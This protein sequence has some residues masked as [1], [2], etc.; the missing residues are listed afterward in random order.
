[1]N[2]PPCESKVSHASKIQ[3]VWDFLCWKIRGVL[4][5]CQSKGTTVSD[6]LL[7]STS[8]TGSSIQGT[9][10]GS[11]ERDIERHIATICSIRFTAHAKIPSVPLK[12]ARNKVVLLQTLKTC[13]KKCKLYDFRFNYDQTYNIDAVCTSTLEPK[14]PFPKLQS[15]L[16]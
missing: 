2:L 13:Y 4:S 10:R 1:M 3:C 7:P 11:C 6:D 14:L 9:V 5:R 8:A 16:M 15:C 12:I